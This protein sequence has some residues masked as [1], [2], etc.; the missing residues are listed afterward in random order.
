[1]RTVTRVVPQNAKTRHR[2][3]RPSGNTGKPQSRAESR[4]AWTPGA[5]S[6]AIYD[7]EQ[8]Y[9]APGVQSIALFSQLAL[10]HGRGAV[11]TDADGREYLDFFAGVGVASLGHAHPKYV[12]ALGDQVARIS[13]GSFVSEHR[14]NFCKLLSSVTPG[15]LNRVQLYSGGSEAVEAAIRLAKSRTKKYEVVGFWGGFHGKTGGVLGLLGDDFKKEL[16]PL[17]PGTYNVPYAHCYQCPFKMKHPQCGLFCAEFIRKSLKV[18]TTGSIAAFIIEPVQGTAGN[19]IPP[20]GF[21]EAVKQIA[22]EEGALLISDEMITAFGRTGKMFGSQHED[23]VPDI[24]TVGKGMGSGFP[25]SG[26]ISSD[27]II[28]SKPFANPSGSSSSYGG[29]PLASAACHITLKTVIEEKLAQNSARVGAYMLER[30]KGMQEKYRFIGDVRGR[31]LM[32]GV[33]MVRDRK[34]RKHLPKN[35]TR[36]LFDECLKRGLI[37]MC[38]SDTIRINPPLVITKSQA[39]DGLARLDEAFAAIAKKF[40]L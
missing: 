5:K 23:V 21:F 12:R 36:T 9:I 22:R 10:D 40:N 39:E 35:V 25:V 26:V 8:K 32:I 31:G 33:E 4:G 20:P 2:G 16:G 19:V 27:E 15:N 14:M 13:V 1:M 7:E 29:N 11:I 34:T 30:L 3:S 17:M 37:S 38:Y 28:Q 24:I 6:K 18:S